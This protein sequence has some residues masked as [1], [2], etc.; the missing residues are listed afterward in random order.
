MSEQ[1]QELGVDVITGFSAHKL[2]HDDG[3]IKGII[4]RDFGI[5]KDGNKTDQYE[6]G[7]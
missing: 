3:K 7:V 4:T 2:V 5:D 1:A 6:P